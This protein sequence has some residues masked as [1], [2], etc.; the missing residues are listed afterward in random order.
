MMN[1]RHPSPDYPRDEKPAGDPTHPPR[2]MRPG[3]AQSGHGPPQP[4]STGPPPSQYT[5]VTMTTDNAPGARV[6]E[7]NLNIGYY[8][9]LPGILKVAQLVSF[10]SQLCQH[11]CNWFEVFN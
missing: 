3:S 11:I 10:L 7:I 8:K 5:T 4:S 1:D 6:T 9:T 2:G